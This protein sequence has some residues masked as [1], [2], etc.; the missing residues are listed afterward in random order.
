MPWVQST[1]VCKNGL[2]RCTKGLG[3][4][5][6]IFQGNTNIMRLA[7]TW[8]WASENWPNYWQIPTFVTAQGSMHNSFSLYIHHIYFHFCGTNELDMDLGCG[9]W[10]WGVVGREKDNVGSKREV[11][12]ELNGRQ[13]EDHILNPFSWKEIYI[14][15]NFDEVCYWRAQLKMSQSIQ[16]VTRSPF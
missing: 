13:F 14:D 15:S 3:Y 16:V 11:M 1:S 8:T 10:G 12:T 2:W 7:L 4:N 9:G 6:L 5:Y